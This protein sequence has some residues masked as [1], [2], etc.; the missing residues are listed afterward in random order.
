MHKA[1]TAA[2][3]DGLIA[4]AAIVGLYEAFG[5]CYATVLDLVPAVISV[6]G[7]INVMWPEKRLDNP[8]NGPQ[9]IVGTLAMVI[10]YVR[11]SFSPSPWRF[12]NCQVAEY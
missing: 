10:G 11:L 8:W 4:L 5:A 9:D 3:I 2:A 1:A 7:G 12:L 6:L